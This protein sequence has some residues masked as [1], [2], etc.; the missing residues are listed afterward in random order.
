MRNSK[1]NIEVRREKV[2]LLLSLG[3]PQSEIARQLKCS[4]RTIANDVKEIR[5]EWAVQIKNIDLNQLV[6]EMRY[7]LDNRRREFYDIIQNTN[8][9]QIKINALKA[10][11]DEETRL[12]NILQSVGMV[13]KEPE[14]IKAEVFNIITAVPRSNKKN[15]K[16]T[17]ARNKSSKRRNND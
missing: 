5:K 13:H 9:D 8:S 2:K 6:A 4:L 10:L 16:K 11:G 17:N 12:M 1:E 15:K 7:E 3:F 14:K